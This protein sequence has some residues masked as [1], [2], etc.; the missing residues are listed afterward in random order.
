MLTNIVENQDARAEPNPRPVP[1]F[2]AFSNLAELSP[3]FE[4]LIIQNTW[5]KTFFKFDTSE[6]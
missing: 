4:R 5:M 3:D 2:S 1:G 6:K